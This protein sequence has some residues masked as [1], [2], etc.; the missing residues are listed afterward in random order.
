M[1][2]NKEQLDDATRINKQLSE[3]VTEDNRIIPVDGT[4]IGPFLA[5]TIPYQ[6]EQTNQTPKKTTV[7]REQRQINTPED[8]QKYRDLAHQNGDNIIM[9]DYNL[10]PEL[11]DKLKDV[12]N[13]YAAEYLNGNT[14]AKLAVYFHELSH[15]NRENKGIDNMP[16]GNAETNLTLNYVDEKSAHVAENL[17]LVNIYDQCKKTGAEYFEYKDTKIK[18]DELLDMYPNLRECVEKNG[19]DL[20]K[21]DTLIAISKVAAESWDE[22]SL[23]SYKS[24][25][26]QEFTSENNS[27][28]VEQIQAVKDGKIAMSEQL[29][30]I[31]IGYGMHIDLP[32]ECQ[33]FIYPDKKE[34]QNFICE[35]E[36]GRHPSNDGL[37]A[38]DAYLEK[39]GLK[40]NKAKDEYIRT[41]YEKIVNRAP[42]ADNTL[43]DLMLNA[44]LNPNNDKRIYYTDAL[45]KKEQNGITV[46]S[47]D[48]DK[49]FYPVNKE[50]TLAQQIKDQKGKYPPDAP[51]EE[52][53]NK[54]T[55]ADKQMS[56]A[57][58]VNDYHKEKA[59]KEAAQTEKQAEKQTE[60]SAPKEQNNIAMLKANQQ[61]SL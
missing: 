12:H 36:D 5:Q 32:E 6:E 23:P 2:D 3:P 61:K 56:N 35:N 50:E 22:H 30:D 28:I 26:F 16:K 53:D 41:Q 47:N 10:S 43:K 40:T 4:A 52:I 57:C 18:T 20:T 1:A 33:S 31:D 17:A 13:N 55:L 37:L 25:E 51:T 38:I 7:I 9:P 44:E 24:G 21:K 34:I 46:V 54:R 60:K 15:Y 14:A 58:A 8:L 19:S 45:I 27:S 29:K 59:A 49:T 48:N 11:A 39:R 42:D